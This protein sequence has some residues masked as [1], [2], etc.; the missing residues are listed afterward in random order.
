MDF[1]YNFRNIV[2]LKLSFN[3]NNNNLDSVS[4]TSLPV[5]A[6]LSNNISTKQQEKILHILDD[7]ENNPVIDFSIL[8]FRKMSEFAYD[9]YSILSRIP[10]GQTI[11]YSALAVKAGK[12]GAARAVGTLMN[13]NAF[14]IIIPCHRVVGKNNIGGFS[15]GL[16]LKEKLLKFEQVFI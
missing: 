1:Y 16:K 15:S 2:N 6:L 13:L 11:S 7:Y 5:N 10:I 9:I 8:N 14:A 3:D 4:F 12:P